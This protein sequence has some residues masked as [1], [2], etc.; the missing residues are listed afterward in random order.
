MSWK[1]KSDEYIKHWKYISKEKKNGKTYYV[2]PKDNDSNYSNIDKI[3]GIDDKNR[4][5]IAKNKR[6]QESMNLSKE[7]Y[8]N[9]APIY[10]DIRMKNALKRYHDA[11]EEYTKAKSEYIKTPIYK[12][13]KAKD[14]VNKAANYVSKYIKKFLKIH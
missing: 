5:N 10:R 2:Y 4:Y 7:T 14:L 13:D 1:P 12:I 6:H 3:L 11:G 8:S 9:E